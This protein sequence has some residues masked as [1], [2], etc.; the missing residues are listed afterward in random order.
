MGGH[1][2]PI[3][4][5]A[6][7]NPEPKGPAFTDRRP[8]ASLDK[9]QHNK[10]IKELRRA[11]DERQLLLYYQP[12]VNSRDGRIVGVEALIRWNHPTRGLIAPGQFVPLL[13]ESGLILEVGS[14]VLKQAATDFLSWT[15]RGLAPLRI[16]V[17]VSPSQL[18][19]ENFINELERAL[20]M[21]KVGHA[22]IDI[23]ITEGVVVDDIEHCIR[24]LTAARELGVRVAIDDF[25][26]G[27]S[28]LR[29]LAR[30]PI[31]SLKI[32]TSFVRMVTESPNDLAIVSAII[33]LAHGLDLDVVAEGV[34]TVEQCKFL[35]LLRCDQM[36]GFLFSKP[37]SKDAIEQMLKSGANT[38]AQAHVTSDSSSSRTV[39]EP[40]YRERREAAEKTWAL[41]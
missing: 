19:H 31:D 28:S 36:Q 40:E 5:N 18:K 22:G 12:K 41:K 4:N 10:G 7:K 1:Y 25:G 6:A 34:E 14:W 30:L 21:D 23:E 20:R 9:R 3:A 8:N 37:V 27:Y 33:V 11:I 39:S 26:T 29:Y 2:M 16:A 15:R 17:N 32:D 35:R 38:T 24:K 13:E